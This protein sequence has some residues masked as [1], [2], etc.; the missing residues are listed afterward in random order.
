[1]VAY[2]IEKRSGSFG[3]G[4]H[5]G[6]SQTHPKINSS[7]RRKWSC[8][9]A[10]PKDAGY[11]SNCLFCVWETASDTN[12]GS[13]PDLDRR[14]RKS[15]AGVFS[16]T[17]KRI[18]QYFILEANRG[19]SGS[20]KCGPLL[21][22]TLNY[23]FFSFRAGS[24]IRENRNRKT[25]V[26]K[27]VHSPR[28]QPERVKECLKLAWRRMK[29]SKPAFWPPAVRMGP[30]ATASPMRQASSGSPQQSNYIGLADAGTLL[31]GASAGDEPTT[32]HW[33]P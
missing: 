16:I 25:L 14:Q 28:S 33:W 20:N 11:V 26:A 32:T 17:P 29:T 15:G 22:A 1:M 30:V 23:L 27:I 5:N 10:V 21:S 8:A 2:S 18:L 24:A 4:K 31:D 7:G 9:T 19:L 3:K 13:L 12:N 6:N